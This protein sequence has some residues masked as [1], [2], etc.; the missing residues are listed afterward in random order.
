MKS[1]SKQAL[2]RA[3]ERWDALLA[4]SSGQELEFAEQ[5]FAV[6]DLFAQHSSLTGSVTD[7]GR[8]PAARGQLVADVLSDRVRAEVSELTQGMARDSWSELPDFTAALENLAVR[9]ILAGASRADALAQTEEQLYSAMRF[10]K[11]ERA[12]R[13]VLSDSDRYEAS[14]RVGL[15]DSAFP[16]SNDFTRALL[17]RAVTQADRRTVTATLVEYITA[18]AEAGEHIVAA[19]TSAMPLK[20]EQE[21]R[22]ARILTETYGREVRLHVG[23]DPAVIGGLR[24]HIGE[25]VIDGTIASRITAA[26]EAFKN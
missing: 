7:A 6:A 3:Q 24:I 18:A 19:V 13:L 16:N 2:A 15:L 17:N 25:D 11:K 20:R 14:A 5:I 21:D 4:E 22:L 10:L 26:R 9:S 23:I 8:T 12:L 1:G